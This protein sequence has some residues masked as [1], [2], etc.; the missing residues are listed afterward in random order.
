MKCSLTDSECLDVC[1]RLEGEFQSVLRAIIAHDPG[2]WDGYLELIRFR[3]H[4]SA[5]RVREMVNRIATQVDPLIREAARADALECLIPLHQAGCPLGGI[6]YESQMVIHMAAHK[7]AD[8]IIAWMIDEHI[9]SVDARTTNGLTALHYAAL[10]GR[11]TSVKVLLARCAFVDAAASSGETPLHAAIRNGSPAVFDLLLQ[12]G[13]NVGAT[14]HG[15]QTPL[16]LAATYSN[17]ACVR[18]LLS[19][20]APW[21]Y[22]L[23]DILAVQGISALQEPSLVQARLE[24]C[25]QDRLGRLFAWLSPEHG[26][27]LLERGARPSNAAEHGLRNP[28]PLLQLI[29]QYG[30]FPYGE[31]HYKSAASSL[32]GMT[33]LL[34]NGGDPN[35]WVTLKDGTRAPLIYYAATDNDCDIQT[36]SLL[37]DYGA[38]PARPSDSALAP[39]LSELIKH[40]RCST[41]ML[42]KLIEHGAD[43]E[44]VD[45]EGRPPLHLLLASFWCIDDCQKLLDALLRMRVDVNVQDSEGLTPLMLAANLFFA[46]APER[47]AALLQ[48]GAHIDARDVIGRTAL[49]YLFECLEQKADGNA[50][51]QEVLDLLL[52][53]GADIFAR[54][55]RGTFPEDLGNC[56]CAQRERSTV[57]R[58]RHRAQLHVNL[59]TLAAQSVRQRP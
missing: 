30:D 31:A 29:K 3:F 8:R 59:H 34:Q 27:V 55:S 43:A 18:T 44:A 52:Q 37:L 50:E 56:D 6:I 4:S 35:A 13:A 32:L 14:V 19:R 25:P 42:D 57:R 20:G 58:L 40:S 28:Y 7:G 51:C 17:W 48:A 26:R 46:G 54:D 12:A 11:D 5:V 47:T 36:V 15:E 33:Q 41:E 45:Q 39:L 38:D 53:A 49:H 1:R 22:A 2:C 16:S 21:T 24:G 23:P 9:C 10:A